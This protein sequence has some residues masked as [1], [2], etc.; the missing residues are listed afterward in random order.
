MFSQLHALP[1]SFLK[2]ELKQNG[3]VAD[4]PELIQSESVLTELNFALSPVLH[5]G[6]LQP[7]GFMVFGDRSVP[8][9]KRICDRKFVS[10][11]DA[12]RV[13]DGFHSFSIFKHGE[14]GGVLLLEQA[15][16]DELRLVQLQ[17]EFR[18]VICTTDT[19]GVT[20]IFCNAGVLIHQYR[21]WQ[22][23]P[24]VTVALQSICRCVPQADPEILRDLLE[25]CFH[26]LSPRKIGATLVWCLTEPTDEEMEN[27]RPNF[28]L[29]E[30]EA[31]I[32]DGRSVA[33]L[34]HL[35]TYSDGA[36]I[37]DPEARAIGIGAQLK[38]SD[39][40]KL[41]IEAR[42]G[43]R[44][45]SAQ[46]FSYDYP[47]VVVFVVSSDGPVTVFSDGMSVTDL[48]TYSTKRLELNENDALLEDAGVSPA[49]QQCVVQAV[50]NC[51][52]FRKEKWS[53]RV[54][55]QRIYSV[56]FAVIWFIQPSVLTWISSL[57]R[58]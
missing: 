10:L 47:N 39:K 50:T 15:A 54:R 43:T 11:A 58:S 53:K 57:L 51:S 34:R 32:G 3:I 16:R 55:N 7:Y 37:V 41:L 14:Y 31:K 20:K 1:N 48:Q 23:K 42:A 30:I 27:M 33:V 22:R 13:A 49:L 35:L 24:S 40:S 25:L 4:A 5:E 29:E 6:K 46:R 45:T 8:G 44:H 56:L 19:S 18:T 2:D 21:S 9:I 36:T 26:D 17:Q 38:Y 12:R 52:R 28:N